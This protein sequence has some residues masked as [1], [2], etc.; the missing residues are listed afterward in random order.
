MA[1][2]GQA[3]PSSLGNLVPGEAGASLK[4][5]AVEKPTVALGMWKA[6]QGEGR[7]KERSPASSPS[8]VALAEMAGA[9]VEPWVCVLLSPI[10][11]V[12]TVG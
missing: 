10:Q 5:Q 2:A 12:A 6:T 8:P 7:G 3:G 1:A 9:G 4:P 11:I